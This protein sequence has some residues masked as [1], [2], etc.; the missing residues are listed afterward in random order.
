MKVKFLAAI[1]ALCITFAVVD[2]INHGMRESANH[3]A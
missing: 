3:V 2:T 1:A